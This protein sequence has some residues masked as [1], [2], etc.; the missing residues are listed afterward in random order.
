MTYAP[1]IEKRMAVRE[2]RFSGTVDLR[3][4]DVEGV[5]DRDKVHLP[6]I[7]IHRNATSSKST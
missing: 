4:A 5:E 1:M 7:K 6:D 3:G 2:N